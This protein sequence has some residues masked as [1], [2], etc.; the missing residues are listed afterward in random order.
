MKIVFVYSLFLVGAGMELL[1]SVPGAS[2]SA[3]PAVSLLAAVGVC[4][5]SPVQLI[6]QESA[7]LPLQSTGLLNLA[8]NYNVVYFKINTYNA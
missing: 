2:L 5:V 7:R 8:W 3:G 4:G 6:P 1:I